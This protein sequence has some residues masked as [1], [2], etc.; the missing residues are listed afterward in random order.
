M[1][2]LNNIRFSSIEE[3][4]SGP[5]SNYFWILYS[6]RFIDYGNKESYY[7]RKIC[8]ERLTFDISNNK[9]LVNLDLRGTIKA[10]VTYRHSYPADNNLPGV[11]WHKD[12]TQSGPY[13]YSIQI[14]EETFDLDKIDVPVKVTLLDNIFPLIFLKN[15]KA[16]IKLIAFAPISQD[17]RHRPPAVFYGMLLKN[18]S[19]SPIK[20][21]VLL[22]KSQLNS[23]VVALEKDVVIGENEIQY[24]LAPNEDLW[25][26]TVIGAVPMDETIDELE[27]F[28]SLEWLNQT[29]SYFRSI[30][31]DL[32]LPQ[33]PF[34]A[35]FFKRAVL[36]CFNSIGM[37]K[38]GEIAGSN[39][40]SFP[41]TT[42]I[43]MKDMYYSFLPFFELELDLFKKGILWFL[44]RSVR[45]KGRYK[46]RVSHSLSN[47]LTPAIMAGLYYSVTGD[48]KLFHEYPE[49]IK[50]IKSLLDEVLKT[51]R[52]ER[53]LF[54]STWISDGPSRGDY[55]TGSN[56]V[57]WFSFKS[58]GDV[59]E[60]VTGDRDLANYYRTIAEYIKRDLDHT[61]IVSGSQGPQYVEG[62]NADGTPIFCHDGEESDTTLMPFYGYTRYDDPAYHNH[63]RVAVTEANPFYRATTKGIAWP[64]GARFWTD[65]TF[66]GYITGL[67][68]VKTKKEWNGPDGRMT[69]I[70]KLTDIDGSIWWWPYKVGDSEGMVSREFCGKCGWASGVF[71]THFISQ[72]LGLR[73]DAKTNT[74]MF[75]PFSPSGD[76]SWKNFRLGNMRFSVEYKRS[77]NFIKCCIENN[78]ESDVKAEVEVILGEGT[79]PR[80]TINGEE[81][82]GAVNFGK[83]FEFNTVKV[84]I[85]VLAKQK[86]AIEITY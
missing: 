80:I 41:A 1:T 39:W 66:P 19:S 17:G 22:P 2:I 31:G 36:Q 16:E 79:K 60:G 4:L 56:V 57:A 74:L 51:R 43:W 40:G 69:I 32:E 73:Y 26:P 84:N 61:C 50:E 70:R 27:T 64:N 35:E 71:V 6:R 28:S 8:D 30:I 81:Y 86:S 15:N 62:V 52:G 77:N 24:E 11:W 59:I 55:H 67:A 72:I 75:R 48:K 85:I 65:A 54:P 9:V 46:E 38:N 23:F 45:Y 20:G 7:G 47:S 14:N 76:F 49:I 3:A 63:M 21:K 33:D 12:F 10:F 83:F 25:I 13:F 58:F 37:T 78:N 18:I 42:E 44:R 34:T 29:L 82:K 53:Y 5:L 68:G